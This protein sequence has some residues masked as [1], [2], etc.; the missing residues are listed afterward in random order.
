MAKSG[1]FSLTQTL[2]AEMGA[3]EGVRVNRDLAG[4]RCDRPEPRQRCR[5]NA[6][7]WPWPARPAGRF[8]ETGRHGGCRHLL[9]SPS[10]AY[11]KG[12]SIAVDG[13]FLATGM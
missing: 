2:A 3:G 9:A 10:A 1:V 13:G 7:H 11:V 8:G 12:H 4:I 6:R 5:R